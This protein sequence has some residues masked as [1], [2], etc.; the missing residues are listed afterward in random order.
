M[1]PAIVAG[2]P[3]LDMLFPYVIVLSGIATGVLAVVGLFALSRRRSAPYLLVAVSLVLLAGRAVVG[4]LAFAGMVE[5][6]LHNFVEHALDFLI[7]VLLIAAIFEAR[8]PNRC[9]L[10]SW[11]D[12]QSD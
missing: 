1:N 7:A 5:V 9:S 10:G 2:L 11:V 6:G 12:R 4:L 8:S 3:S